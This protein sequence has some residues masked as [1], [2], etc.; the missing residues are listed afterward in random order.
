LDYQ[1]FLKNIEKELVFK[2]H[3]EKS[4]LKMAPLNRQEQ[5]K[6]IKNTSQGKPSSVLI[7]FYPFEGEIFVPFIRRPKYD[8]VHSGQIALPGGKKEK[9]DLSAEE[10][11]LR[12][13]NEEV[14]IEP[15]KT[16]IIG[17]LSP[18]YIPPSNFNVM[19]VV[20]FVDQRPDF[21]IDKNEVEYLLEFKFKDL[22]NKNNNVERQ[23]NLGNGLQAQ[24]P[25]F[26]IGG[27]IIWGATAMIVNELVDIAKKAGY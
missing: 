24:V 10:T 21:I 6:K 8:G 12:E 2:L 1:I 18:L 4:Q 11:A 9:E 13:A 3:G 23:I 19:P 15:D 17:R 16:T 7:L 22:L 5:M 26:D 27:Q 14:G 25:C 20:A